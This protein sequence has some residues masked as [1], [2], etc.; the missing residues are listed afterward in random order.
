MELRRAVDNSLH[1]SNPS[2]PSIPSN[3][4]TK[5]R[6]RKSGAGFFC[7]LDEAD[8]ELCSEFG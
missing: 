5:S 3:S 4:F 7:A 1:A 2:I 6:P 8:G